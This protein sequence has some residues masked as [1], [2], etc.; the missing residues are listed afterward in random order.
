MLL[1]LITG[2]SGLLAAENLNNEPLSFLIVIILLALG[3]GSANA[4]N[5]VLERNLDAQMKRTARRRPLPM[6]IIT[7][8]EGWLV[9]SLL[10]AVS[11]VGFALLYNILS[12]LLTLITIL[13]YSF[14]YTL[15]LKPRTP[16][17]IVIG[18]A[19]GAMAPVIAFAAATGTTGLVPWLMFGIIFFWTPPHFWSLAIGCE[20]D[21]RLVG[22]PM[23]PLVKGVGKT[24]ESS[25]KY[26]LITIL[27]T[28]ALA[29]YT[30]RPLFGV[31]AL[32]LGILFFYHLTPSRKDH[33]GKAAWR[34]FR[35]SVVYL[36]GI[37]ISWL[38]T[39][40]W[41]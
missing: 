19:A 25:R 16:Q 36:L 32:L 6:G 7:P 23:M 33:L 35:T 27:L 21:Y 38:F 29:L 34:A 26:A 1:V 2:A 4:F 14:F 17:N 5:Q 24:W 28:L 22:L 31:V 9:A 37:F 3:G 39:Q 8:V 13:F 11:V 41:S 40:W 10:G 20:D 30:K 18:G 12:A 15:Y